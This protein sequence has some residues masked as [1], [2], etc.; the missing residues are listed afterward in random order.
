MNPPSQISTHDPAFDRPP[1]L[2]PGLCSVQAICAD[3]DSPLVTI[4]RKRTAAADWIARTAMAQRFESYLLLHGSGRWELYNAEAQPTGH[5]KALPPTKTRES[6]TPVPVDR[7]V[8]LDEACA[9]VGDPALTLLACAEAHA[10]ASAADHSN[11]RIICR[12]MIEEASPA[13]LEQVYL[14]DS[15]RW[16]CR[17]SGVF[18]NAANFS[19]EMQDTYLDRLKWLNNSWPLVQQDFHEALADRLAKVRGDY[20]SRLLRDCGRAAGLSDNQIIIL[21]TKWALAS[22]GPKHRFALH[23][24]ETLKEGLIFEKNTAEIFSPEIVRHHGKA[25]VKDFK[26]RLTL[27]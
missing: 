10:G 12:R 17:V 3:S 27:G 20:A 8:L 19:P 11:F 4:Y 1:P 13:D 16:P 14:I 5:G 23:L 26:R 21:Q 9:I 22:P 7:E 15:R 18:A 24:V 2:I 6:T 25:V